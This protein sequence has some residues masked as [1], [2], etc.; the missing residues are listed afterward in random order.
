M[1]IPHEATPKSISKEIIA[2]CDSIIAGQSPIV[3][4]VIPDYYAKPNDCFNNVSR[5]VESN[6]GKQING[7]TIWQRA[8]IM[9]DFEAHAVWQT[10]EGEL[11]DITPHD[12]EDQILFL[13]DARVNYKGFTIPS[14]RFALTDSALVAE[15]IEVWNEYD[16]FC[17]Q[18]PANTPITLTKGTH[19]AYVYYRRLEIDLLFR[20][21]VGRNDLC[22]CE[23]GLKFKKCCGLYL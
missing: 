14:K 2:G 16:A 7:W 10:T 6:G 18:Y 22:P 12:Q 21:D 23:S 13:P 20:K 3:V 17:A 15:Y 5:Q 19:E 4:P 8:N 9:I 1:R 11:I